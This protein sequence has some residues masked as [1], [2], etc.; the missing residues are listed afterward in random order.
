MKLCGNIF[1]KY[2]WM[3]TQ[4][5]CDV[6][7]SADTQLLLTPLIGLLLCDTMRFLKNTVWVQS[8]YHIL[9]ACRY[10]FRKR[11][12]PLCTPCGPQVNM[13]NLMSNCCT[14][15]S[16]IQ[17]PIRYHEEL[18]GIVKVYG[19]NRYRL[20]GVYLR[21]PP[22]WWSRSHIQATVGDLSSH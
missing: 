11:W 2:I 12:W 3:Q 4:S 8:I 20:E 21:V 6:E 17:E 15:V 22:V 14:W 13:F 7:Q 1:I 10:Q 18:F 9:S 16:K 5:I 19:I